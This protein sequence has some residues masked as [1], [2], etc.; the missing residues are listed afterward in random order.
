MTVRFAFDR[1]Q[2]MAAVGQ[3]NKKVLNPFTLSFSGR[4]H[5]PYAI[6]QHIGRKSG[7]RYATPV[8]AK[9]TDGGF[10]IPLPY[11]EEADWHCNLQAAGEAV[12]AW[13][14]HAY[15]I[16]SPTVVA[17]SEATHVYDSVTARL[18]DGAHV[19]KYL[20]VTC[21]PGEPLAQA[22]YEEIIAGYPIPRAVI[23]PGVALAFIVAAIVLRRARKRDRITNHLTKDL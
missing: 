15:R 6:V 10:I 12:I 3:F 4:P 14:G 8:L 21:S 11:G 16:A 19:D 18:L 2:F 7:R 13:H 9:E 23:V 22:T 17:P 20:R 1:Q 5:S